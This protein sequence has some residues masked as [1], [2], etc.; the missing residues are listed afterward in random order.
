MN[1]SRS[2]RLLAASTSLLAFVVAPVHASESGNAPGLNSTAHAEDA[3][4]VSVMRIPEGVGHAF[5]GAM[6]SGSGTAV[7]IVAR[8]K[9]KHG[10]A[11]RQKVVVD[12][13]DGGAT[14]INNGQVMIE[15]VAAA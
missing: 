6:V 10:G 14:L 2:R 9:G 7:V 13:G 3:D 8:P 1:T 5:G 11:I 4:H 15:A 12:D